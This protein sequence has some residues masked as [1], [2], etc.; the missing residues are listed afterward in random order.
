MNEH[1]FSPATRRRRPGSHGCRVLTLL[2]PLLVAACS[3]PGPFV[4]PNVVGKASSEVA[5]LVAASDAGLFPC[6]FIQVSGDSAVTLGAM[7]TDLTLAPGRYVILLQCASAYHSFRPR[8]ELS[9]RPGKTYRITG[10]LV[11]NSITIFNMKMAVRV[12]ELP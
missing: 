10:Y 6:A 4:A 7:R 8:T 5:R 3:V 9:V 2:A 12:E 11:D 1:A